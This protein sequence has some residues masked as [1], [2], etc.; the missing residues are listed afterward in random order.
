MNE[1]KFIK[2]IGNKISFTEIEVRVILF[3]SITFIIGSFAFYFKYESELVEQKEYDYSKQDS[4]FWGNKNNLTT[5]STNKKRVDY[6][7]ELLD[8]S[9]DNNSDRASDLDQYTDLKISINDCTI[10]EL[11][12]L[13]G[14][15]EKTAVSIIDYRNK[16]GKFK[17]ADDLL[18]VSGIGTK[19]LE[20]IKNYLIIE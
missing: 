10:E 18:E 12:L 20:K 17:K 1:I 7:Q 16:V 4:M 19:K 9:N 2:N 11:I 8:F 13:P 3:I 14:I 5:A 6:E 15:G